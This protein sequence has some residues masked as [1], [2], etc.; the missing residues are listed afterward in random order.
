MR[1]AFL[2]PGT[3][4]HVQP[5]DQGIIHAVKVELFLSSTAQVY[6]PAVLEARYRYLV[7]SELCNAA[8]EY[9]TLQ[10]RAKLLPKGTAGIA[11]CNLPT[12]YDAVKLAKQAWYDIGEETIANCWRKSGLLD[13]QEDAQMGKKGR[14]LPS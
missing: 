7:L 5:C 6:S 12:L 1:I 13:F 14:T 9:E 2:P 8:Q 3:T 11:Y 4:S 10:A